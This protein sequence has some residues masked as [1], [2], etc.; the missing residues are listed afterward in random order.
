MKAPL[1]T[2]RSLNPAIPLVWLGLAVWGTLAMMSA[3]NRPGPAGVHPA[4]W[5]AES[6][7]PHPATK[8]TLIM[9]VQPDCTCSTASVGELSLL[10]EGCLG[11]VN[12]RVLFVKT[13]GQTIRAQS[14]LWRQVGA[15]PGVSAATD[16]D[17]REARL[18][19][20]ETSGQVVL[21]G[22]DGRLRFQGGVTLYR[23][24]VGE[25]PGLAAVRALICHEPSQVTQA[26]VFGCPLFTTNLVAR[27]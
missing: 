22:A 14:E 25:N 7:L 27:R 4:R 20:A 1:P 11:R 16:V 17:G 3:S 15:I 9:F 23:G 12:T 6:S 24:H 26:P 19:G 10:M 13:A 2:Q 21:Y 18:F 5:P 8:P